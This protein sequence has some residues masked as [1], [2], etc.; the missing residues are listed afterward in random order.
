MRNAGKQRKVRRTVMK[1]KL[2]RWLTLL[3]AMVL[4]MG[5][6]G[7]GQSEEKKAADTKTVANDYYID[8]TGLGMKLTIYLRLDEE[9]NFLFSNT[10]DFETN[11]SSGTFQESDGEYIMVYASVNGEEKSVSEGLT[12]SFTVLEDGSLDFTGCDCIYYG[13]AKATTTSADNPDAKLIAVIVPEDFDA[14]ST[15]SEFQAGSYETADVTEGGV[16]YSHMISF[17]EDNSYIHAIRYEQDGR[18]CF[19]YEIGTYGV[20]TTQLALEPEG[21]DRLSCDVVDAE[22]LNVSVYPY[23][24]AQERETLEFTKVE[25]PAVVAELSGSG[26][27]TGD[28][29]TFDVEVKIYADGSYESTAADFTETGILAIDTAA[30]YI[31]QYPDHPETAVRGLNQVATV[32]AGTCTYEDGALTLAGLRVRKSAGLARYECTVTAA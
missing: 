17:Y 10:L 24:G 28:G 1:R 14:P 15:E 25:D 29:E 6:T 19:T 3:M 23:A 16:T 31:K 2:N 5:L 32:P 4:V 30:E 12:S 21:G 27:G 22:T 8:L 26:E 20:N 18:L 9:G 13:S 11:K 7:C